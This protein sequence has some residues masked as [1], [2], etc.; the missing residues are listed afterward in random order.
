MQLYLRDG[1]LQLRAV[2]QI[3]VDARHSVLQ[4]LGV[5]LGYAAAALR[6]TECVHHVTAGV[7]QIL[8]LIQHTSHRRLRVVGGQIGGEQVALLH[9]AAD[10]HLQIVLADGTLQRLHRRVGDLRRHGVLLGVLI[11][12]NGGLPRPVRQHPEHIPAEIPVDDHRRVVVPGLHAALS[13]LLGVHDDPVDAGGFPQVVH[14]IVAL[15]LVHAVLV[16]VP[17]VQ[18]S[19]GDGDTARVAVGVPVG[20]DIQPSVQ[21]G[22]Q[23]DG[24]HHHAG[25]KALTQ[26]PQIG[27]E[28]CP[29]I[30]HIASLCAVSAPV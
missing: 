9:D 29:N 6:R 17:L 12:R 2:G 1:L 15:V 10:D 11:I 14:H 22:Q 24:D 16:G 23:R 26:R 30:P 20:V 4:R 5:R 18:R 13:L 27:L 7:E 8:R 21:A 19:H 25:E 28:H 3:L